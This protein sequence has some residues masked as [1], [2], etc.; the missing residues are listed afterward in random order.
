MARRECSPGRKP[1]DGHSH[2]IKSPLPPGEGWGEGIFVGADLGVR[3]NHRVD[4]MPSSTA[5]THLLNEP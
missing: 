3:P 4:E 5:V 1:W 2:G